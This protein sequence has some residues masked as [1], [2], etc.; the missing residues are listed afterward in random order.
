MVAVVRVGRRSLSDGWFLQ[1]QAL[2]TVAASCPLCQSNE[3]SPVAD[4]VRFD[5][6]ARVL[7]CGKC[8]LVFLD[9]TSF[10]FPRDFYEHDYHQTYLTHV[11]PEMLDPA[12]HHEKMSVASKPWIDR[13]RR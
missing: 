10:T 4:R 5:R 1:G 11:D 12:R 7:R 6:T 13:V 3:T 2:M 9:Q 8:T